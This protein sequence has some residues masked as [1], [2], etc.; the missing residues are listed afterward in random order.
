ML[1][2]LLRRKTKTATLARG[3]I[4]VGKIKRSAATAKNAVA[5]VYLYFG[6]LPTISSVRGRQLTLVA[7]GPMAVCACFLRIWQR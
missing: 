1:K 2:A 6:L 3:K 5:A 7:P 4:K